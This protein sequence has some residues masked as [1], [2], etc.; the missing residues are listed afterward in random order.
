MRCVCEGERERGGR[1]KD[2]QERVKERGGGGE[3]ERKKF[4]CQT[5]HS[6]AIIYSIY[7]ILYN[8]H[9]LNIVAYTK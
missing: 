8:S 6:T 9:I 2:G 5:L 4:N 1:E 7:Y 3:R